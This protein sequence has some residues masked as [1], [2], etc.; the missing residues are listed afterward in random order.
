M[1]ANVLVCRA[2]SLNGDWVG[3]G[4]GGAVYFL[5]RSNLPVPSLLSLHRHAL[6]GGGRA[7]G[8]GEP[9]CQGKISLP[10]RGETRGVDF[11]PIV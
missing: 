8:P 6:S 9:R 1:K 2:A 11:A 10:S 5:K 7:D 4:C 3:G